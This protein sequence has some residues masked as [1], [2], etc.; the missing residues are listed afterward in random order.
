MFLN[1]LSVLG[2]YVMKA[3]RIPQATANLPEEMTMPPSEGC[4]FANFDSYVADRMQENR[5]EYW[6]N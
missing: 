4:T 1:F 5:S 6:G 3:F 2:E